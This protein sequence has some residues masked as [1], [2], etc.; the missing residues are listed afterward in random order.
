MS[1]WASQGRY[2]RREE[3]ASP[4]APGH[5]VQKVLATPGR[6]HSALFSS[7]QTLLFLILRQ[8][9]THEQPSFSELVCFLAHGWV[10]GPPGNTRPAGWGFVK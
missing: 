2:P 7:H 1:P 9:A 3:A 5:S 8:P 6:H 10:L 4:S